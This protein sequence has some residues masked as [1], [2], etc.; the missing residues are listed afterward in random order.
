MI[1]DRARYV[2]GRRAESDELRASRPGD[3]GFE[4]I[5]LYEPDPADTMS[6]LYTSGSTGKPKGVALSYRAYHYGSMASVRTID[7]NSGDRLFSYLPLAHITENW[8]PRRCSAA[9][10]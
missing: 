9:I 3:R 8:I 2:N 6:I 4:W 7:V 5:S 10:R 1:V